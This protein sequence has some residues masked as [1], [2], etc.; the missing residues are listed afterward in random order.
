MEDAW[1]RVGA[2]SEMLANLKEVAVASPLWSR[3]DRWKAVKETTGI[4]MDFYRNAYKH[5]EFLGE[6]SLEMLFF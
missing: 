1:H 2:S 5:M 4:S 3:G 6:F